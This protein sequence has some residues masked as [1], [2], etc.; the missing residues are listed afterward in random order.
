MGNGLC[1]QPITLYLWLFFLLTLLLC[2]CMGPSHALQ[3]FRINLLHCGLST[4]CSFLQEIA[5]CSGMGSSTACTGICSNAQSTSSPT[6][7]SHLSVCRDISLAFFPHFSH[8]CM[9]FLTLSDIHFLRGITILAEGFS[10]ALWW[11][12][13]SHLE[14]AM[15]IMGHPWPLLTE[16]MSADPPLP[17]P[18]HLHSM[19][20]FC[21]K[22]C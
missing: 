17:A 7:F 10:C 2:F 13:W 21:A 6:F 8:C 1:H 12:H 15:S 11:V 3:S 14:P 22:Y 9:V 16:D 5:T 18:G 20:T 4:S 19:Q